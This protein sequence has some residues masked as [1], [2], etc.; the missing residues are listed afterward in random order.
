M[1]RSHMLLLALL[2]LCRLSL[3]AHQEGRQQLDKEVMHNWRESQK[4]EAEGRLDDALSIA[5]KLPQDVGAVFRQGKLLIMLG[6]YEEAL[7]AFNAVGRAMPE[8][9]SLLS[10]I[11]FV[12]VIILTGCLFRICSFSR[13]SSH[14][15][16]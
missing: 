14:L 2:L 3:A 16:F 11:A 12:Q 15:C 9:P 5:A 10:Y 13:Q 4:A 8:F 6:K 7:L 1:V